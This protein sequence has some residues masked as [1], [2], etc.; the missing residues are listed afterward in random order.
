MI[1]KPRQPLRRPQ[2]NYVT[3]EI[4][5]MSPQ[6]VREMKEKVQRQANENEFQRRLRLAEEARQQDPWDFGVTE[7][8]FGR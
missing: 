4:T 3:P 1:G 8:L 2:S 6:A 5:Q 7:L